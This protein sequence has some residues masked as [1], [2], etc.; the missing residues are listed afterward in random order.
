MAVRMIKKSW[1]V[2]FRFNH[3]RYRERS[4]ENSRTGAQ[5]YEA[6]LRR[7]L[8][9]GEDI[10]G[11]SR[12]ASQTPTFEEFAW[13][14]FREYVESNCKPAGIKAKQYI[15]SASLV[16]FFGAKRIDQI[17]TN[18]VEKFKAQVLKRGAAPK[19]VNTHLT[20]FRKCVTTAFDWHGLSGVAP[21]VVWLKCPPPETDYLSPEECQLLLDHA[22]GVIREMILMGLRTGMRLGEMKGLQWSSIDWQQ[23]MITVRHS[24]SDYSKDLGS[25][26]T[27]RQR[28]IPMCDDIYAVLLARRRATGYVFLGSCSEK[29]FD[30][31]NLAR[32]LDRACKSAGLRHIGWHTLRH[33]FASH[34]A[35]KGVPISAIQMLMGHSTIMMTMRY[36]H[37]APSTLREAVDML[38]WETPSRDFGQPVGNQWLEAQRM[39]K[40]QKSEVPETL[41]ITYLKR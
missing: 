18:D 26:K 17:T 23:K 24:K 15:L 14:W 39:E 6:V 34:L 12:E 8:A 16:P 36:A 29:P 11:G 30:N 22:H 31:K 33:T 5:A 35:A 40:P 37:L 3:L 25:P 21:K 13:R 7:K 28:H 4:P 38:N 27:N 1:W 10:N 2:D 32:Q 9:N 19:T 41:A 20:V